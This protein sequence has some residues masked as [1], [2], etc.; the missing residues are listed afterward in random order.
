MPSYA[1]LWL[2]CSPRRV[3]CHLL[4]PDVDDAAAQA[5]AV[6][7]RLLGLMQLVRIKRSM[8]S[9]TTSVTI[10]P[11]QPYTFA[12]SSSEPFF[13][14]FFLHSALGGRGNAQR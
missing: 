3:P 2:T 8:L 4:A 6:G 10:S 13:S 5:G 9:F 11:A 7:D 12:E 14:H 1:V